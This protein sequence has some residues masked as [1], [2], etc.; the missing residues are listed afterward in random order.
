MVQSKT[1]KSEV[2]ETMA[3]TTKEMEVK[4]PM[5]K[6]R[7]TMIPTQPIPRKTMIHQSQS[8]S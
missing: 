3:E 6:T 8:E 2:P 1:E 4:K 5:I 7:E